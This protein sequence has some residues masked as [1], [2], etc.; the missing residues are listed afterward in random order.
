MAGR[1]CCWALFR[2]GVLSGCTCRYDW[3]VVPRIVEGKPVTT[4]GSVAIVVSRYNE[5][6]TS[7]LLAGALSTLAEHG[8]PDER[9]LVAWVPGAW[10]LSVVAQRLATKGAYRAVICLGAVIRGETTH[11]QQI[12]RAVS[13]S[14]TETARQTGVP[15]LFGL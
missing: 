12:N 3:I 10:E 15:V 6:I 5:S 14:L 8:M 7:K 1:C 2:S 9:I 13:L 11:D 4:S